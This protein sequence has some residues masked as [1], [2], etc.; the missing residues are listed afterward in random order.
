MTRARQSLTLCEAIGTQ[1]PFVTELDGLVLRSRPAAPPPEPEL[2]H[3]IWCADP[4]KIVLSWPGRFAPGAAVHR[5]LGALDVGS[6]LM[7]RARGNG[8]WALADAAGV[9]VGRMSSKFQPPAGTIVAVRVAA[10][11]VRQAR[12]SEQGVVKCASW[13]LVLPEIE[14]VPAAFACQ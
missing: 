7:L 14:Y 9:E 11:L 2:A 12:E 13:E 1:H 8:G 3:R 4:E 10:M 6:A 5:A